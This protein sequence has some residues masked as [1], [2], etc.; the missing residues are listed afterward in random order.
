MK[1]HVVS[2]KTG[3]AR[4]VTMTPAEEAKF[5]ASQ[6]TP[7]QQAARVQVEDLRQKKNLAREAFL[8]EQMAKRA[9]DPDA[10]RAL[11]DWAAAMV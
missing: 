6:D 5:R 2:T 7:A 9:A 10:P 1:K 8:D 3:K 4:I 11:K